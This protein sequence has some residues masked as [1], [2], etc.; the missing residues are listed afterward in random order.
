MLAGALALGAGGWAAVQALVRCAP[1][2]QWIAEAL[3]HVS[4]ELIVAHLYVTVETAAW[5]AWPVQILAWAAA[6]KAWR[7][8][9]DVG[10]VCAGVCLIATIGMLLTMC[11]Q[12]WEAPA[13]AKRSAS[14]EWTLVPVVRALL[15]QI[16][17]ITVPLSYA[18][19]LLLALMA[20]QGVHEAGHALAA[21]LHRIKPLAMGLTLVAPL[22]P[23]AH[24]ALPRLEGRLTRYEQLRVISAGVWH[25]A[26]IL[27]V[28]YAVLASGMARVFWTDAQALRITRSADADLREWLPVGARIF[29]VNDRVLAPMSPSA[30]REIWEA[31][32]H[33]DLPPTQGWCVEA[34]RWTN[35]SDA[36]CAAPTQ[37]ET[38]FKGEEARC[39][40][41]SDV[42][43]LA[44]RCNTTCDGVCVRPAP[45]ESLAWLSLDGAQSTEQVILRGP[46]DTL[47]AYVAVSTERLVAWL[48]VWGLEAVGDMAAYLCSMLTFS[49]MLVNTTLCLL[50]MLPIAPLDGGA[51][52]RLVL[53]EAFAWRYGGTSDTFA[54]DADEEE[55]EE[56]PWAVRVERALWLVQMITYTLCAMALVRSLAA[57]LHYVR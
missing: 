53:V 3:D 21:G 22:I 8:F 7:R 32:L 14:S 47:P 23:V 57:A 36:C 41:T 19:P 27:V 34:P 24:V 55:A 2:A 38:C 33:N 46:F 44:A 54:L 49:L 35:A 6:R 43:L 31:M 50:N 56:A 5:N 29:S 42:L 4:A 18:I 12:L 17:G 20:S 26:C 51:Y 28:I 39:L 52:V 11:L 45:H 48:R 25:N 16:P 37:L 30:R 9:Y 40:S 15:T 1:T 10:I 13:L